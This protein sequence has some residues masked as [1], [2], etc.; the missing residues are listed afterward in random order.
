[1][2]R[3]I[4]GVLTLQSYVSLHATEVC[5]QGMQFFR[6]K[7]RAILQMKHQVILKDRKCGSRLTS[8]TSERNSSKSSPS[9]AIVVASLGMVSILCTTHS[10]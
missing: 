5:V 3:F 6:S 1:M 10:K 8:I 2:M 9:L 4:Y 7:E